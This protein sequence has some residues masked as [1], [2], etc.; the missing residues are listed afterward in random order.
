M[1]FS[2]ED[3]SVDASISID[4]IAGIA[5]KTAWKGFQVVFLAA[6]VGM[7][8]QT[9]MGIL[10]SLAKK[11]EP[12]TLVVARSA[13]G[14]RSVLYPVSGTK[15]FATMGLLGCRLIFDRFWSFLRNWRMSDTISSLRFILG[16]RW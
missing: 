3:V 11:L 10:A 9:K 4:P 1:S 6:L 7:D 8:T 2:C 13:Q 12:G 16:R 5:T 14:L 15:T